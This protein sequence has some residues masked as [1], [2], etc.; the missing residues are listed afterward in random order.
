MC[1]EF[2]LDTRNNGT[3]LLDPAC[4][5]ALKCLVTGWS[6]LERYPYEVSGRRKKTCTK[7]DLDE[8]ETD[9]QR[10]TSNVHP[11]DPISRKEKLFFP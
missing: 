8:E 5:R 6:T 4:P 3:L 2:C 7:R 1:F 9:D 11:H 10:C